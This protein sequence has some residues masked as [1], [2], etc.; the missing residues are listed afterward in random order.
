MQPPC[1]RI[2]LAVLSLLAVDTL[3]AAQQPAPNEGRPQ[4]GPRLR[5]ER[6]VEYASRDGVSLTLDVYRQDPA[7]KPAPLVV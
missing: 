2:G 1:L 7:E 3:A 4:A 5:I 6:D